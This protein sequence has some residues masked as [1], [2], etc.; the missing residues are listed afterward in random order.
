MYHIIT[1]VL[2]QDYKPLFDVSLRLLILKGQSLAPTHKQ[3]SSITCYIFRFTKPRYPGSNES[4]GRR[5]SSRIWEGHLLAR[6]TNVKR[7]E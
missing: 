5:I 4:F 2:Y 7:K 6:S 1:V 3:S